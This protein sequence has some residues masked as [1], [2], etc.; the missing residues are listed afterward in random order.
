[1]TDD[2]IE[3]WE[4]YA[5]IVSDQVPFEKATQ[6]LELAKTGKANKVVVVFD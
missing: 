6:A 2:I 4:K 5:E 1:M 3:N